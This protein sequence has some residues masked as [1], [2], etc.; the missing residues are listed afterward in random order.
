MLFKEGYQ[1][2]HEHKLT[3]ITIITLVAKCVTHEENKLQIEESWREGEAR[4]DI[5]S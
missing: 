2:T 1:I 4:L 3:A 5:Y